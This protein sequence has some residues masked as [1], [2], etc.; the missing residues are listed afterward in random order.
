MENENKY[1]NSNK[2]IE[3]NN[4]EG[5][6]NNL[7]NDLEKNIESKLNESKKPNYFKSTKEKHNQNNQHNQKNDKDFISKNQYEKEVE[8]FNLKIN[9][10]NEQNEELK[11]DIKRIA[12]EFDNYQKRMKNE[13]QTI[14]K[15]AN[16]DLI[17]Q[18]S[19]IIN[20]FDLALKSSKDDDPLK[21][22][23][24][25]IKNMFLDILKNNGVSF[26]DPINEKY[27]YRCHEALFSEKTNNK[28]DDSKI[29]EV[30]EN[31]MKIEDKIIKVAKVKILIYEEP[32]DDCQEDK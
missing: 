2:D 5:L 32:K 11:Y 16:Q 13:I 25:M 12:A 9:K 1:N 7:N 24:F 21:E 30:F 26:F 8:E 10:L 20:M 27:D 17:A 19:N 3:E 31:G 18:F 14:R 28:E 22:G 23:V 6:V 29:V 4:Q 15:F